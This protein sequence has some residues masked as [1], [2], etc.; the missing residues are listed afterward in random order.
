MRDYLATSNKLV[1]AYTEMISLTRGDKKYE[2][3]NREYTISLEKEENE[4]KLRTRIEDFLQMC[5]DMDMPIKTYYESNFG[6]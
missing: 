3:T 5:P 2:E 4:I 1:K 6:D